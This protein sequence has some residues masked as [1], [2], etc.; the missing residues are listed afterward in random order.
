M[1]INQIILEYRR[2]RTAES[3]GDRLI[4]AMTRDPSLARLFKDKP[5]EYIAALK[6]KIKTD[7]IYQEHFLKKFEDGDPTQ[8]KQYT[9]WIIR[10]YAAGNIKRLEDVTSS[11]KDTLERYEYGKR[12]R[13]IQP[14]YNDINR[15]RDIDTLYRVTSAIELPAK[16]QPGQ[17][18]M[19]PERNAREIYNGS[20]MRIIQPLDVES[21]QYYG[22]GTRWCTSARNDNQFY[23]YAPQGPLYIIIPKHPQYPGEKYQI[24][25]ETD[26]F[27]N[28][29]DSNLD[30]VD[31]ITRFPNLK[32]VLDFKNKYQ[33]SQFALIPDNEWTP[34]MVIAMMDDDDYEYHRPIPDRVFTPEVIEEII[35]KDHRDLMNVIPDEAWTPEFALQAAKESHFDV[36]PDKFLKIPQIKKLLDGYLKHY[37]DKK[38]YEIHHSL[39]TPWYAL[40]AINDG[41]LNAIPEKMLKNPKVAQHV[42]AKLTD[43]AKHGNFKSKVWDYSPPYRASTVIDEP[44][45][46]EFW[47]PELAIQAAKQGKLSEIPNFLWTQQIA[48]IAR[49]KWNFTITRSQY[50]KLPPR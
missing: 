26:Q 46:I 28:E 17:Q 23:D 1:K 11:I 50:D 13:Q 24:Q 33:G 10:Q 34:Q 47:T 7:D 39:W 4:D 20:D 2:D 16:Q 29:E 45:N 30:P 38:Y 48:D 14:P 3:L 6:E 5:P 32:N 9:P 36:F 35:K 8:N 19:R 44:L 12:R 18:A 43:M 25:F 42:E 27:V 40:R 41:Y 49:D 37:A 21:A 22:Q 15:I 31:L